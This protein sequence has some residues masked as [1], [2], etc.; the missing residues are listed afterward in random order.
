MLQTLDNKEYA[1]KHKTNNETV[2]HLLAVATADG[3]A[4]HLVDQYEELSNGRK[5]Y[6]ALVN[7]YEG[8]K[9]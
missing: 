4:S 8:D 5:A 2:F 9:K 7:W 1:D 6:L 3:S